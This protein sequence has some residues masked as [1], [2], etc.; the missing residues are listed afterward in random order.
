MLKYVKETNSSKLFNASA[1]LNGEFEKSA[2]EKMNEQAK[3]F[4]K[5]NAL[6]LVSAA[7]LII[8]A[9]TANTTETN[10]KSD[11]KNNVKSASV[12]PFEI[13]TDNADEPK[14][15]SYYQDGVHWEVSIEDGKIV[16]LYRDG[17]EIPADEI[18]DYEDQVYG[19]LEELYDELDGFSHTKH[20]FKTKFNFD[21]DGMGE[22][23]FDS[24]KFRAEMDKLGDELSKLKDLEFN[25]NWDDKDFHFQWDSEEFHEEMEKLQEKLGELDHLDFDFNFESIPNNIEIDL[26]GL[27]EGLD[28]LAEEM[29]SLKIDLSGL[30]A[31]LEKLSEFLDD[32]KEELVDDGYIKSKD[33]H[34]DLVLSADKMEVN[35]EKLPEELHKKYLEIY[36]DHYDKDIT[37]K[38]VIRAD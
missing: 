25:F 21:F 22:I 24:E 20:R 28:E 5:R 9:L 8:I 29:K 15:F 35:G 17:K 2:G 19:Q 36:K 10:Y 23:D 6:I 37:D 26:S 34:F 31:E 18:T 27:D 13:F 33:E 32:V 11:I 12:I 3:Q 7:L 4:F 30:D 14:K 16:E 1:V 38:F